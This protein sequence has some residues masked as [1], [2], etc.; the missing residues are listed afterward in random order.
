[1]PT[2]VNEVAEETLKTLET[3][4]GYG[5]ISREDL[6][7]SIGC[8]DRVLRQAV[9]ELRCNGHL[10]VADPE[11]G[12]RFARAGEEVYGFTSSLKSRIRALRQVTEAMER[13]AQREFGPRVE[14]VSFL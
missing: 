12:Y 10:I 7:A 1:M 9:R 14:Q 4:K 5:A 8:H 2:D 6:C 13:A 11:G 3:W